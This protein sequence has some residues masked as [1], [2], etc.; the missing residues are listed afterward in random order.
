MK[1]L[2]IDYGGK[3]IGVA[4]TDPTA[5]IA[6]PLCVVANKGQNNN[7]QAIKQLIKENDIK[8]ILFGLPVHA[9]GGES[10]LCFE[11]RQL[12]AQLAEETAL[13]VK[14]FDERYS[15]LEAEEHIRRNLG[16]TNPQK[17]KGLLDKVAA[18]MILNSYLEAN[19]GK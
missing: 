11:V 19:S 4:C 10:A 9:N 15:S 1:I 2:C 5:T 12:G 6:Y 18:C 7:V 14:Y 16:V 8:L 13:E 3:R 17:I